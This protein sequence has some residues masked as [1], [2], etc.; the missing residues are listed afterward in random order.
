MKETSFDT[1]W[2]C[3]N[4]EF[5]TLRN[6]VHYVFTCSKLLTIEFEYLKTSADIWFNLLLFVL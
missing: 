5:E 3:R 2:L 1:I 6:S 4:E